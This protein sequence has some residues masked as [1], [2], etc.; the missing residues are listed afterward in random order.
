[1]YI[2]GGDTQWAN[3]FTIIEYAT[4]ITLAYLYSKGMFQMYKGGESLYYEKLDLILIGLSIIQV[5]IIGI[6]IISDSYRGLTYIHGLFKF[7][8]NA[9]ITGCLLFQIMLWQH[10]AISLYVV[11]YF[12]MGVIIFDIVTILIIMLFETSFFESSYCRSAIITVLIIS[13]IIMNVGILIY[14]FYKRLQENNEERNFS[15]LAEEDDQYNLGKIIQRYTFSIR[16]MKNYYLIIIATFT[17]SY[18]VDMYWKLILTGSSFT[19]EVTLMSGNG[20]ALNSTILLSNEITEDNSTCYY[21]GS[22]GGN[23]LFGDFLVC[24]FSYI[25]KDL[26]P[27]TYIYIS[28]FRLKHNMIT[29]SSSLIEPL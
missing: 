27:H 5:Y 11:K 25:L 4:I 17:L 10:H 23:F 8:Q 15:L 12:I 21:Y 22:L 3:L 1:M 16:K 24:N 20:T 7:S 26:V 19:E 6:E 13:S 28:L 14:A 18:L 9:I 29:R 2:C